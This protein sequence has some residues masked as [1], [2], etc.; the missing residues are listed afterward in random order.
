MPVDA[1]IDA[2]SVA[3]KWRLPEEEYA[4]QAEWLLDDVSA[5]T[6]RLVVP[7]FWAYE[8][9]SILSKAVANR[10]IAEEAAAQALEIL[11]E[12]PSDFRPLPDPAAAFKAARRFNRT[13]I[14]CFYLTLAEQRGCDFWTDDRKLVRAL[15][16]RYPFVRWIGDYPAP[17]A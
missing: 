10:R 9:A 17:A 8:I 5:G 15:A 12:M 3:A 2:A 16:A 13:L 14:D 7:S 6:I 11:L 1:V 4:L